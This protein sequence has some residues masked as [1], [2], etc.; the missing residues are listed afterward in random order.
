MTLETQIAKQMAQENIKERMNHLVNQILNS[1]N[2][3]E[4]FEKNEKTLQ[5]LS[6]Q[7]LNCGGTESELNEI[8]GRLRQAGRVLG[9]AALSAALVVSPA[10]MTNK[11]VTPA[12]KGS[13]GAPAL[14]QSTLRTPAQKPTGKFVISGEKDLKT[15][16]AKVD[17][18]SPSG[19]KR[20]SD[21]IEIDDADAAVKHSVP[22]SLTHTQASAAIAN[23]RSTAS[24]GEEKVIRPAIPATPDIPSKTITTRSLT[25]VPNRSEYPK[26]DGIPQVQQGDAFQGIRRRRRGSTTTPSVPSGGESGGGS[27]MGGGGSSGTS[28]RPFPT[29]PVP[30][31]PVLGRLAVGTRSTN[32]DRSMG[33]NRAPGRTIIGPASDRLMIRKAAAARGEQAA[34]SVG[35]STPVVG[36]QQAFGAVP[37]MRPRP[38]VYNRPF[39]ESVE[40]Y[41]DILTEQLR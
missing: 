17:P 40:Y 37:S 4:E 2:L 9:R 25:L 1:Q 7:F 10:T 13:D 5:E 16:K 38:R 24:G 23:A 41:K 18:K 31:T 8:F 20:G 26:S 39:E 11:T 15:G 30:P 35:L 6:T 36:T 33:A 3:N 32:L 22:G 12:V 21:Q 28:P 27:G 34:G 19:L 29:P 14:V